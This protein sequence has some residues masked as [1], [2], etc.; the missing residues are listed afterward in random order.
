MIKRA[1]EEAK[2]V[3]KVVTA[4]FCCALSGCACLEDEWNTYVN[5]DAEA[6]EYDAGASCPGDALRQRSGVSADLAAVADPALL[7]A[8]RR[9]AGA[10]CE[11]ENAGSP[12][13]AHWRATIR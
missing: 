12:P 5:F 7:D 2:T 8:A 11:E 4:I 3:L 1:T 6:S 10:S 13:G 9:D